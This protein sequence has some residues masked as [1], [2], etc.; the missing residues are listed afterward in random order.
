LLAHTT[1]QKI[2]EDSLYQVLTTGSKKFSVEVYTVKSGMSST[3]IDLGS[4]NFKTLK[5]PKALMFIDGGVSS[6]EAGE[7]WHL[8]DTRVHMPITKLSVDR[9]SRANLDNYNVIV[10]VSGSY[11]LLDSAKIQKL[12]QWVQKGNTLITSRSASEWAIKKKL[13][14]ELLVED[15]DKKK[16]KDKDATPIPVER[17]PYVDASPNIGKERVGGAIFQVDLDLTHPLAFGFHDRLIPV[18]RNSNVWLAPSK[19]QYSTVGKYTSSPHI[20]GFVSAKNMKKYL[21]PS[22]SLIVSPIGRG[23][24][25]MFADNPNFRGSWYGTNRLFLNALFFGNHISVPIEK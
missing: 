10:M 14:K 9:F 19:S 17:K 2:S 24:V 23:R 15:P 5:K 13:V 25:V 18:Y 7:V 6:Y 8:L 22:A 4:G 3:G 16:K 11:G 12:K 21:T 1:H 20:D